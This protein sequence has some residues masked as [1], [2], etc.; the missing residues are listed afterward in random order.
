ML[1][2]EFCSPTRVLFGRNKEE[3]IGAKLKEL[4]SAVVLIVYGQS[5]VIKS[6]LLAKVTASLE[7]SGIRYIELGG[8]RINPN[9]SFVELGR[10]AVKKH[11]IDTILAVGGGSVID[12]AKAISVNAF[13]RGNVFD[14]NDHKAQPQRAI[15]VAVIL[16]VAGAG[17][18]LSSSCVIQDDKR[19]MKKGFNTDLVR[20]VLVIENP[21]LTYTVSKYQTAVGTVD[22]LMHTLERYFSTSSKI[23]L[24]DEFAIGLLKTVIKSG[25]I[26]YNKP[27]DYDGRANLMLTSSYSH[28][29]ITSIGKKYK[30]PCHYLEHVLSGIYPE[31][32]HGA[33]LAVIF[34]AWAEEYMIVEKQKMARL[35]RELFDCKFTS[36]IEGARL[37]ID[38]IKAYFEKLEMPSTFKDLGIENVNIEELLNQFVANGTR[39][40][41]HRCKPLDVDVA[42]VIY[43]RCK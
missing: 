16:T 22:I 9:T 5:S 26:V 42:K 13:Y 2:F 21:E 35:A 28:N 6:G 24:A 7:V 1:N 32:A 11:Y 39:A 23:E 18:E 27:M 43:E 12:V 14:F 31:V 37:F 33:G 15:P 29:G 41:D 4:G 3:E 10:E 19:K 20:P 38:N 34:P 8:V 17:S 40:V 30:M 25:I 36:N